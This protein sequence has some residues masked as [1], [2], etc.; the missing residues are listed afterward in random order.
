MSGND[1]LE[2]WFQIN[3]WGPIFDRCFQ[4]IP[5]I[6]VK[7]YS[8]SLPLLLSHI[9]TQ[10]PC[11]TESQSLSNT[12]R[13]NP[14]PPTTTR[15]CIGNRYDGLITHNRLEYGAVEDSKDYEYK[16]WAS[17][18]LKLVKVLHDQLRGLETEVRH[19]TT[20]LEGFRCVGFLTAGKLPIAFFPD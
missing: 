6:S 17:D 8:L 14:H 9:L 1:N 15:K 20:A 7:R 3:V 19:V 16:K 2:A 5:N 12:T 4:H 18:S 13:K 11:S 10:N